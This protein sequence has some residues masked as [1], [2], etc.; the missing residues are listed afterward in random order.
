M[1]NSLDTLLDILDLEP[2]EIGLYRGQS[3]DLGFGHLFGGQVLGQALAA[4][5]FTVDAQR[6]IHSFHSYF[7]RAGDLSRPVIY[8]VET[9]RDGASISTRRVSAIQNGRPIFYLTGS[10]HQQE[11]GFEHQTAMPEVPGPEG[12]S[13]QF[14]AASALKG[15]VPDKVLD[16]F[17]KNTAIE[18]R[19]VNPINPLKP[20]VTE[21]VRHVWMKVNG[22]VDGSQALHRQLLAYASDLNFLV[23]AC[24]PHGVSFLTPGLKMATVDHSMWFHRDVDFSDWVLYSVD[25][26]NAIGG[27]GF[28]R[29]Q[30][31][32]QN[33]ELLASTAQEGVLRMKNRQS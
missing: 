1:H 6:H 31:F 10:F 2:L 7:L 33:G 25:S 28:V 20:E 5:N 14:Q 24:Q 32:N 9:L 4:A 27:R 8:E 3:Q 11:Q 21:P 26:P 17:L 12:L 29:G 30:I 16:M 22:Q 23:T 15:Q 13:N 19:L 18:M